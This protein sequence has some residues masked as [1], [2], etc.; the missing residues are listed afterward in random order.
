MPYFEGSRGRIHHEAW[1]PEEAG[2]RRRRAAA[3]VRRAPRPVRRPRP[4]P[5][6]RRSRGTR[7]GLCRS[8]P[9][10]RRAWPHRQLGRLRERRPHV[11]AHRG[12]PAPRRAGRAG[13]ALRRRARPPTCSPCA[14]RSSPR[15]R[16]C[17]ARPLPPLDWVASELAGESPEAGDLDPTTLFSTHPDYVHALMHDPLCLQGG[18]HH[19]TIRAV[20]ATWPEVA[21]ALAEGRPETAG[22]GRA[23]GGRPDRARA[24]RPVRRRSPAT[25]HSPGLP[26]R[27]ARRPQRARPRRRA[28]RARRLRRQVR[29][30]DAERR[31]NRTD[32][33]HLEGTTM[34]TDLTIALEAPTASTATD[35]LADRL[36]S[37]LLGTLDVLTVHIGDQFGLYELLHRSGPLSADGGGAAQR[38]APA[39]RPGVARAADRGRAASTSRT[40]AHPPTSAA[41]RVNDAHAAV[42]CDRDSLAYLTPFARM[43]AAAAI[44]M[45]A[46]ARGLPERRWRGL[47]RL[48]RADADRPGRGQPAAVPRGP[49]RPS[50]F[51]RSRR[52]TPPSA[53]AARWP[54]SAAATAGP[55]SASRGPTPR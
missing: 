55:R 1:L 49:R 16:C 40:P 18:F 14:I 26:R 42:L 27:P 48:R 15:P 37:S 4:P 19:A 30:C 33:H 34:T 11:G 45:P 44:Q 38:H 23:R 13:R 6:G 3:R 36:F 28:R 39:L 29:H 24:D 8:R 46:P 54:T 52:S 12:R 10:R 50:G 31:L 17:R 25:G 32:T 2:P 35:V 51:P 21:A 43:V 9:Q 5:D 41:T 53:T 7:A 20:H 47:E 22:P